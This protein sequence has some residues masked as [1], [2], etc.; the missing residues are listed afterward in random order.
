MDGLAARPAHAEESGPAPIAAPEQVEAFLDRWHDTGGSERANYQLFL[1]ELCALLDLPQPDPASDDTRDNAYVFERRVTIRNPDGSENR[2][3]IDLYRRGCFVLEAKQTGKG[4]HTQGWDKAMLAAQNQADQ[5]VRALPEDEGRPPF[6]VVTDVGRSLELYAEFSRSGGTYVPY[7]DPSRHRIRLED[8]RDPEIQQRLHHLWLAPDQLDASKHAARVTREVSA[9]LAELAKSLEQHGFDVERVAHFLK[10][11]LF[12][13]FSEDVELLPKGSFTALL[14]RLQ[15]NPEHFPDAM[16]SLWETMNTGGYEGQLMHKLQRFNGGLFQNIDPIPLNADQIG[17]LIQAARADWRF[18]EPA[19]FGTLLERALDPRERHKLGAHYTPRAYVER[20]VMPTLIEPL[21]AEWNTVQVAAEAWLQQTKPEKA[22]DELHRFHQRLREVRV[23]DPACGSGNFL[24]VALEHLKRLE[25]EVLNLIRDLS[26]GQATF[27]TEGLTVDPHQFLGLEINPRAAAIAEIVLWIGYLQWHYRLHGRLSLPEPILRDF[28]NIE[29]RDALIDFDAR[30]PMTD[31]HG[32]PVTIWDGISYKKS[33]VTGELIPDETARTPVYHYSNPRRAEWPEADYIVGNPPFIGAATMR[34]ALGDGYVDAVRKVFKGIV[35]DSADFVMYWWHTAAGKVRKAEARRFGFITTNSLRQTFN[36]RV[37]EPHLNDSKRPLSL[38]F[39]IP[40][41]PWVDSADGAAVRIAMTVGVAGDQPGTLQHVLAERDTGDD[42]RAV[43]LI[44]KGGKL[45]SDLGVGA[46]IAG[47]KPLLSNSGLC[48]RGVQ[49]IGMG[50]VV[51]KDEALALGLKHVATNDVPIRPYLNGRD[52]MHKP[53]DV[54]IIDLFGLSLSQ[55]RD[56]FPQLYQWVKERVKPERDQN[57]R[58]TYRENWWVFGEPVPATRRSIDGLNRYIA[59]T[60]TAKHRV[61]VFVESGVVPDQKLVTVGTSQ[62]D[63]LA[64]L[65]SRLHTRW[66]LATGGSLG[67]G[68]DPVYAK[69]RSFDTF[70][71]P[72]LDEKQAATIGDLAERI[73]AH[74][75]A[76]QA[77]HADLTLTG[78]YNVLEKL[79]A[80]E[81]LTAKERTI[82]EQGLVSLLRE[83]HDDLD[84]AVFDPYGWNDL[85]ERLVGRPGATTPLPDK[86]ADQA[87]AE[88]ELL[89]RLVALNTE[90]AAEEAQGHIRWL[91]PDYQAPEATQTTATLDAKPEAAADTPTEPARK[92]TWPKSMPDQVEAVRR[93]LAIGPQTPE[94]LAS[95]FKRKPTKSITQVLAALQILGQATTDNDHWRLT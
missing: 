73:D 69:G 39:A 50:F 47:A 13:M 15:Q 57:K 43:E 55:V 24:Y 18:V 45:F 3:Y 23:L 83:L 35:P 38:A 8:L 19:I 2:G 78:M 92:P 58:A 14:E 90:R 63:V 7:P 95:H 60:M 89:S 40:D 56:R 65:S 5:Y 72:D 93:L 20:L 84:R 80:E 9:R 46:N 17:L 52:I 26:A 64:I 34:R 4:L 16:R 6:I 10:R 75:K 41:H 86:P 12:T 70:P 91:R 22:L 62:A 31:D 53:R 33:P 28:H 66:A 74:R 79:R 81:P 37:L 54:F 30:E 49:P 85:A 29:C 21:R 25:G 42:A 61:F 82:H 87:E 32:Q 71:F 88:E 94:A 48:F 36:R 11:C 77:E 51:S 27:D 59:T 76:R 1:T 67:V 68:N 44:R